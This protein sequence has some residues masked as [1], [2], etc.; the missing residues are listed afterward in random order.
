MCA[1][2]IRHADARLHFEAVDADGIRHGTMAGIL[3]EPAQFVQRSHDHIGFGRGQFLDRV[4]AGEDG[5]THH[6]AVAR[7]FDIVDHVADKGG[8]IAV[9][10][11]LVEDLAD[12]GAFVHHP[13]IRM[14]EVMGE[15]E[16][17]RLHFVMLALH[18]TEQKEAPSALAAK[19]EKLVEAGQGRDVILDFDEPAMEDGLEIGQRNIGQV[20]LVKLGERQAELLAEFLATERRTPVFLENKVGRAD[21][22][23][24][25]VNQRSGPIEEEVAQHLRRKISRRGFCPPRI[26]R[27]ACRQFPFSIG[28]RARSARSI[29]ARA[30]RECRSGFYPAPIARR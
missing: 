10:P 26:P 8:F 19:I 1:L 25:I 3:E 14:L 20:L 22:R 27:P 23:R 2:F 18:R 12:L 15:T 11:V 17:G 13:D 9:Q 5:N 30:H 4:V 29:G 7:G 24:Q 6:A 28:A 21:D 16:F